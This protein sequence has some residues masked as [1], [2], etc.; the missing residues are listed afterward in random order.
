MKIQFV[1]ANQGAARRIGYKSHCR[2]GAALAF[3]CEDIETGLP[4]EG[5]DYWCVAPAPEKV[6]HDHG[7]VV[8]REGA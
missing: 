1:D 8:H 7:V 4:A 5:S 6:P 3:S 2:C